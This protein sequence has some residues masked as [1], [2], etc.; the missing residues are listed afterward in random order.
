MDIL[1]QSSSG[2]PPR[3]GYN[4]NKSFFNRYLVSQRSTPGHVRL[5]SIDEIDSLHLSANFFNVADYDVQYSPELATFSVVAPN[6][7]VTIQKTFPALSSFSKQNV[8]QWIEDFK[9]LTILCK[10]SEAT[11]KGV[12]RT[13]LGIQY[14]NS[15]VDTQTLEQ[16]L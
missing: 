2:P 10:W 12:L 11:T 9:N 5:N 8:L 6:T 1:L 16:Q 4:I 14:Q 15:I 7:T 3:P 13:L